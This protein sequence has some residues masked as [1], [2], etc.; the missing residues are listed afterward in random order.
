MLNFISRSFKTVFKLCLWLNLILFIVL[1]A[2]IAG[3]IDAGEGNVGR[4]LTGMILGGLVGLF[5][6]IM[7]GGAITV[8]LRI[9]KNLQILIK[10]NKGKP[11]EQGIEAVGD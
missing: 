1:G 5:L 2:I 4:I 10:L 3:G 8:F 9:D 7:V 11:V 6:N